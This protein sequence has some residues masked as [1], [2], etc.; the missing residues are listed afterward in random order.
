MESS[1]CCN[2]VAIN[3]IATHFCTC[4]DSTAVVPC[5][6][7]CSDHCVR[8][9]MRVKRNFHQIW[10]A[11]G[12]PLVKRGPEAFCY[13]RLPWPGWLQSSCCTPSH[14]QGNLGHWKQSNASGSR[15]NPYHIRTAQCP[16]RGR[17]LSWLQRYHSGCTGPQKLVFI[18]TSGT[19]HG[20]QLRSRYWLGCRQIQHSYIQVCH[21]VGPQSGNACKR[22]KEMGF[23]SKPYRCLFEV[24]SIL[25]RGPAMC[26]SYGYFIFWRKARVPK[27]AAPPS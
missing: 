9:K 8:I 3:Q 13:V 15:N 21:P 24:L 2:C 11:M 20:I 14:T 4:H 16:T 1:P 12:K 17:P 23:E 27:W 5:T 18:W 7:F 22:N 10:I 26:T 25:T 19:W 6:K